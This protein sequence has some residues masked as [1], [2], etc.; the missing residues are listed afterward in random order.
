MYRKSA[1]GQAEVKLRAAGLDALTRAALILINGRNAVADLERQWG[2]S[3]AKP[4]RALLAK[5]L[6]EPVPVEVK[7]ASVENA[8]PARPAEPKAPTELAKSMKALDWLPL[9]REVARRLRSLFGHDLARVMQPLL[10]AQSVTEV[11]TALLALEAKLA[12]YQGKKAAAKIFEGLA[13]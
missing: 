7:V 3:M 8:Q 10:S 12:M 2:R 11:R 1:Q 6:I 5:G 13:P 9:Q 4:L